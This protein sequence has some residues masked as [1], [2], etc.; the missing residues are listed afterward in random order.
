[1]DAEGLQ[2]EGY[3]FEKIRKK[4]ETND[5]NPEQ[6]WYILKEVEKICKVKADHPSWGAKRIKD[7]IGLQMGETT[8]RKHLSNFILDIDTGCV[9]FRSSKVNEQ[10][11]RVLSKD[12]LVAE[13]KKNHAVDHRKSDAVYETI[14]KTYFPVT[15]ENVRLLFKQTVECGK[16]LAAVDLPKTERTRR[17]IP[18]SYPN[19][20]WQMDLKKM[21]PT[22]G[23]NYICN[24][25]DCYSRFAFG[26]CLKQK[27]PKEVSDVI[28]RFIYLFGPPRILQ[29]DNGKEFNNA[30]LTSVMEDFKTRHVNGR[31]YHPQSQDNFTNV[32]WSGSIELL[33]HTSG[34]SSWTPEIGRLAF[35][36]FIIS[37]TTVCTGLPSP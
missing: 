3:F 16:C 1:M 15:R 11:R 31:P 9:F 17:P 10:H 29:T 22:R 28:L 27:T 5:P 25:V 6:F 30:D 13:I 32:A 18:A 8:V 23:Y 24:I 34:H 35:Q 26:A 19:S 33:L 20:R 12:E 2:D 36:I 4:R 7:E 14:R 37:T 21:P